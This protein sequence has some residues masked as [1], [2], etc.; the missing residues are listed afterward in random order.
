[1]A[2]W[3]A[4]NDKP[5]SGVGGAGGGSKGGDKVEERLRRE[6]MGL[7][8]RDRRRLKEVGEVSRDMFMWC[9]TLYRAILYWLLT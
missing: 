6:V 3:V 2:P 9:F 5:S 7:P 4:A 8:A 1:M